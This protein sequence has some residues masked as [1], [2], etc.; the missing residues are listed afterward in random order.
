MSQKFIK[1]KN[2]NL[3]STAYGKYYARAIYDKKPI[4]TKE[5]ANFIQTQA[6][7]KKSDCM[8]VLDELGAA[9]KHYLE[10]GQK[11]KIEG[12]GTFKVGFSSLGSANADGVSSNSIYG[13]RVIFTPETVRVEGQPEIREGKNGAPAIVKP[14]TVEK[15]MVKDVVFEEAHE[16]KVEVTAE[17]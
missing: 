11:V 6:T 8:A 4:S 14:F 17:P 12:I 10:M 7:V 15:V 9:L 16:N 2:N 13:R 1:Y 5:I 3:R